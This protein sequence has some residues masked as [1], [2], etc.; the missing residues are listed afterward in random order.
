[1]TVSRDLVNHKK[2]VVVQNRCQKWKERDEI[3]KIVNLKANDIHARE[4]FAKLF[5]IYISV[6]FL[7][8]KISVKSLA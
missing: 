1:M 8:I 7:S 4:T 2:M 6:K 5:S 3:R